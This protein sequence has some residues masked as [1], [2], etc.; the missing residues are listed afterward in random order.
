MSARSQIGQITRNR[1]RAEHCNGRPAG[2]DRF[3]G[4]GLFLKLRL[5][6]GG[7]N[8][9][10]GLTT[11]EVREFELLSKPSPRTDEGEARARDARWIDLYLKHDLAKLSVKGNRKRAAN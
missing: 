1:D 9:L 7:Q 6:I 4:M 11:D 3:L 10:E 2:V 5:P 8:M